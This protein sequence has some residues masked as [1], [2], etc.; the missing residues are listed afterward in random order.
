ME[1]TILSTE[2]E[3]GHQVISYSTL[4]FSIFNSYFLFKNINFQ[5]IFLTLYTKPNFRLFGLMRYYIG[6]GTI[7]SLGGTYVT[8]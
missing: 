6:V 5:K 4:Q 2:A 3:G 1:I 8:F 7:L